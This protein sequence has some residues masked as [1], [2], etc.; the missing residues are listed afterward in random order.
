VRNRGVIVARFGLLTAASVLLYY[1]AGF[2]LMVP[3]VPGEP[4]LVKERLYGVLPLAAGMLIVGA[5][6]SLGLVIAGS[7]PH[8]RDLAGELRRSFKYAA[9]GA[10]AVFCSILAIDTRRKRPDQTPAFTRI[11][12]GEMP[13]QVAFLNPYRSH[14][15]IEIRLGLNG[16]DND[17]AIRTQKVN[18]DAGWVLAISALPADRLC[19][20]S[21]SLDSGR[22]GPWGQWH[23]LER[24]P[25]S[26][27]QT[28]TYEVPLR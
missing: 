11:K 13:L 5:S 17:P 6:A 18:G 2:L 14:I 25:A 23:V 8:R 20:R 19:W 7:K 15:A 26:E 9:I 4:Y 27:H 22:E 1:G 24:T 28:E 12:T 21:A 16:C 3:G 10:V